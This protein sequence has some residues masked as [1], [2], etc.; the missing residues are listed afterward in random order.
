MEGTPA[1]SSKAFASSRK[2]AGRDGGTASIGDASRSKS[3][4]RGPGERSNLASKKLSEA[5]S[6]GDVNKSRDNLSAASFTHDETIG[7]DLNKHHG[8]AEI[9][10]ELPRF[11]DLDHIAEEN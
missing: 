4:H 8:S 9:L 5:P 3:T 11:G 6:F 1:P 7:G 10:D 2:K